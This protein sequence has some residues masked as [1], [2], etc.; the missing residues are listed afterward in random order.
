VFRLIKNFRLVNEFAR[1][2]QNFSKTRN[3]SAM[4]CELV[5]G[6]GS[7]KD[8]EALHDVPVYLIATCVILIQN[9][10]NV[11]QS[12]KILRSFV[13]NWGNRPSEGWF[14]DQNHH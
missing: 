11:K 12:G 8:R 7:E 14:Q 10:R 3:H 4:Q 13:E 2:R 5:R 1:R 9:E 6:Q